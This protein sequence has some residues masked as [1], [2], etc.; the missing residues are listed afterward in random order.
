MTIIEN[1]NKVEELL[2][3]KNMDKLHRVG[4]L[5]GWQRTI[6]NL[7]T[8]RLASSILDRMMGYVNKSIPEDANPEDV[9]DTLKIALMDYVDSVF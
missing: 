9:K 2:D 6:Y 4:S 1:K 5:S 8:I 7:I 3:V